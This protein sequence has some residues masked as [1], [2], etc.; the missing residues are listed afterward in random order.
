MSWAK[1][2]GSA[3]CAV[4]GRKKVSVTASTKAGDVFTRRRG[5]E[6]TEG[7]WMQFGVTNNISPELVELNAE[8]MDMLSSVAWHAADGKDLEVAGPRGP[9][10]QL[11]R[12]V[13]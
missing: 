2:I 9:A 8:I 7:S 5:G 10:R 11:K 13:E 6:E 1:S 3:A 12:H 4:G